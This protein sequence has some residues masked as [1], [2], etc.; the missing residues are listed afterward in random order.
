MSGSANPMNIFKKLTQSTKSAGGV[1]KSSNAVSPS[2]P[3][4][5]SGSPKPELASPQSKDK[6]HE[7][8]SSNRPQTTPNPTS[9]SPSS[10]QPP[11]SASSHS[12]QAQKSS[13]QD[14]GS[15]DAR[16]QSAP[17]NAAATSPSQAAAA[18]PKEESSGSSASHGSA[19]APAS[20]HAPA[21]AAAHPPLEMKK[22]HL[23]DFHIDRTLGTGSFGRVHLV[24]LKQNNR[25]YA[26]K[27]L[28]KS[29]VV[30]MKQVEHT[31]NE[32]NILER[33]RH[34]FLVSML[35]TFQDSANIYF[36]L[37]YVQGGELFSYLRRCG[38]FPNHVAR[39][40]AAEV[41]LAFE[42]LHSSDIIY[43]DLKPENLLIDA[44]GHIKITDFG[45]AK[46]VPDVT[47]TLC[48]TP[49]YLAPEIIQSKGYGKAVDWWALGVLIYEMLA[50]H[51][52]FYDEDHFK[53]YEKILA[54]KP[55]F[56]SH[57]DPLAKDLV[58]HLLT[59]DLTKRYGNLKGGVQDIK[60][61][62]WFAGIEWAKLEALQIP[63]PYQPPVKGEGDTSNFDSYPEDHEPYG[64]PGPD[65]YREKFK[66]F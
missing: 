22:F 8:S 16:P 29:E 65:P 13:S 24:R 40:Y 7:D 58:K 35:G 11:A 21:P 62:K 27:V 18:K 30:R 53:L 60:K 45:F 51:P 46:V 61:H 3:P 63:A 19:A 43:R 17:L 64:V 28:K 59:S 50:G 36:V 2:S 39:F 15:I 1:F 23:P 6:A 4:G 47:W 31:V 56:P 38:R 52:P 49:D 32:K 41:V 48:G 44:Q 14:K 10:Q 25:F 37:E 66:D 33:L 9:S 34:P 20:G 12:Q 57:F 54:C 5:T 26:M 55:K 42:N